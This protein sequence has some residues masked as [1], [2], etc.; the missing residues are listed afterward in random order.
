MLRLTRCPRQNQASEPDTAILFRW[1]GDPREQLAALAVCAALV[2]Q[3]GAI[4]HEP[5]QDIL[6]S[7]DQLL[8][9]AR[10]TQGSL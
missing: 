4:V 3:F 1:A 7:F 9:K 5:D 10:D 6:L 8:A 2:E